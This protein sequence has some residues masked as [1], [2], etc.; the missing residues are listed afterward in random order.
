MKSQQAHNFGQTFILTLTFLTLDAEEELD[1]HR[2]QIVPAL[3]VR[4]ME[5]FLNL[6]KS[7][8]HDFRTGI[9]RQ[10]SKNRPQYREERR[11]A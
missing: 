9:S 2:H 7:S 10:I 6:Q 4:R 8:S 5:I 11:C 3:E 1:G